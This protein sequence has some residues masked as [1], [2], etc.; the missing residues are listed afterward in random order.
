MTA[1]VRT[2]KA[3]SMSEALDVVRREMGPDAVILHTRELPQSRLLGLFRNNKER[4]E[5]TAGLGVETGVQDSQGS[6]RGSKTTSSGISTTGSYSKSGLSHSKTGMGSGRILEEESYGTDGREPTNRIASNPAVGRERAPRDLNL[7]DPPALLPP[8]SKPA[9]KGNSRETAR[10]L[11]LPESPLPTAFPP[12]RSTGSNPREESFAEPIHDE[13]DYT[14]ESLIPRVAPPPRQPRPQTQTLPRGEQS[15]A[16]TEQLAGIRKLVERLGQKPGEQGSTDYPSEWMSIAD[17]LHDL[18]IEETLSQE[19]IQRLQQTPEISPR[20][21]NLVHGQLQ[22]YIEADLNCGG[23][24]QVRPGERRVVALVGP[25]GVGKTTTIAKLAAHY[26]LREGIRTGLLT[27]DTF[28]IAAVEQLRTYAEIIDLPMEVAT[29]QDEFQRALERLDEMDLILIDT[30]GR[31]PRDAE[32]I[33]ELTDLLRQGEIDEMHLV[34][35]LVSGKRSLFNTIERFSP[36]GVTSVILSKLDEAPD[37]SNIV[38][39]ARNSPW[40]IS[41]VTTGQEVPDDFSVA[42][43]SQLAKVILGLEPLPGKED[44]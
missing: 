11:P 24:I 15:S 23:P 9:S 35:S 1:D 13:T 28:R 6:A 21:R 5:I 18:G 4:V 30:A 32:R 43:K 33:R 7:A 40:P 17:E 44:A 10:N 12:R 39:V 19:W 27:I 42:R 36:A 8:S 3:A 16:I 38:Q 25:T 2:F 37:L 41:Y 22:R 14:L 29:S 26:S 34:L 31:S 20:D